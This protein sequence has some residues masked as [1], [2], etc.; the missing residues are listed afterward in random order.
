MFIVSK[1]A[2]FFILGF[3]SQKNVR[4]LGQQL[5]LLSF[6]HS[7]YYCC[8]FIVRFINRLFDLSIVTTAQIYSNHKET[9]KIPKNMAKKA[10]VLLK[11]SDFGTGF[12]GSLVHWFIGKQYSS[13]D[14]ADICCKKSDSTAKLY[15]ANICIV[16][17]FVLS[18]EKK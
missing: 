12:I 4:F 18:L 16:I 2:K 1:S 5:A 10:N 6:C 15:A 8:V 14:F 3:S 11:A 17:Y 7:F 9:G 13:L